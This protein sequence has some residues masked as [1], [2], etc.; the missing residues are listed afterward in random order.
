MELQQWHSTKSMSPSALERA[1]FNDGGCGVCIPDLIA[2]VPTLAAAG[3]AGGAT[4]GVYA[5]GELIQRYHG[6][7]ASRRLPSVTLTDVGYYTDDGAY[8][9]VWGGGKE[10]RARA[11]LKW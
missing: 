9:Y 5:W 4:A 3:A 10:R 11:T 7:S 6:M 1:D 8:Y 2:G